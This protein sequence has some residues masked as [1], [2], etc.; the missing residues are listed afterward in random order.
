MQ[1]V[2]LKISVF[3]DSTGRPKANI[4]PIYLFV[5]GFYMRTI[6]LES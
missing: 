4:K 3:Q 1:H 6:Q 5:D 2:N